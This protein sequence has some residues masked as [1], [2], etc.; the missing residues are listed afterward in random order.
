MVIIVFL[1][2]GEVLNLEALSELASSIVYSLP[3]AL[4]FDEL[5]ADGRS[6]STEACT[7]PAVASRT[8][9]YWSSDV[10]AR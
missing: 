9:R 6:S 10:R 1:A 5:S 7:D 8:S 4:F 2:S 3:F